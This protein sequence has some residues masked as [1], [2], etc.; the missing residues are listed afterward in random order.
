LNWKILGLDSLKTIR[1]Y[2]HA[3]GKT[4]KLKKNNS[5]EELVFRDN[6][7]SPIPK[8][9]YKLSSLKE[10]DFV[11]NDFPAKSQ[12][13]LEKC[14]KLKRIN[15]SKNNVLI[16][17]LANDTVKS[18]QNLILSFNTIERVPK[19]IGYFKNLKELQL[20]ENNIK[21]KYINSAISSLENLT[22]LSFYKNKLDSLPS[23][24]FQ[25]DSLKELDLYFNEISILPSE[26]G[27]LSQLERFYIAHNKFYN[28]PESIGKLKSLKEFYIHHNRISYLP[29]SISYLENI[30]D[31]H[32]Q[33]NY[34]QGFPDFVLNFKNLEDLDI[35]YNNIE[36]LPLEIIELKKL[37]LLWMKGITFNAS[38]KEQANE[39]KETI[40]SLQK[41]GV[42]VSIDLD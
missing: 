2:N 30:T 28:I 25:L 23:S 5:I 33:N 37:K 13:H 20:A 41:R 34:F 14:E 19:E 31:F 35:S 38:N 32:L 26:I 29:E 16:E 4:I 12:F 40:E 27:N 39:I 7:Y 3:R 9:M 10:V 6:P 17:N 21:S 24:I 15:L 18:L 8:N 42:K 11:R 36:S 1:I 22:S